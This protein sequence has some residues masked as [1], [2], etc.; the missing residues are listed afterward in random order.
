MTTYNI[1]Q[2]VLAEDIT[3]PYDGKVIAHKG[4]T[5]SRKV[6]RMCCR[7]GVDTFILVNRGRVYRRTY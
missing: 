7:E 4:D 6:E 1:Y 2:S 5:Y 3:S